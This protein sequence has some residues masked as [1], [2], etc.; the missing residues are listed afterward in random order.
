MI[1]Q[2][3]SIEGSY[4]RA[5]SL[6]SNDGQIADVI[7]PEIVKYRK[8]VELKN[9]S[10]LADATCRME[11]IFIASLAYHTAKLLDEFARRKKKVPTT[12][13]NLA[14]RI[15]DSADTYMRRTVRALMAN[16][17]GFLDDV[18]SWVKEPKAYFIKELK[19]AL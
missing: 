14:K 8:A 13:K 12:L 16:E 19:K 18:I 4:L 9:N 11:Q 2:P 10:L 15:T 1:K 3:E 6:F 17:V 7:L 5:T